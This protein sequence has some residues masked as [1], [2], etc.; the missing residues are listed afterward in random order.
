METY[1]MQKKSFTDSNN[2]Y[3]IEV[4]FSP[5]NYLMYTK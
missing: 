1:L 3:D 2:L 5:S 4:I